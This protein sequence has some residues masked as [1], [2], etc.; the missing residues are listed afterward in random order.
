MLNKDISLKSKNS[1]ESRRE[2]SILQQ[3]AQSVLIIY[4]KGNWQ[5]VSICI[6]RTDSIK[7]SMTELHVK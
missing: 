3:K 4:I 1:T 6:I 2:E 5:Q 7:H